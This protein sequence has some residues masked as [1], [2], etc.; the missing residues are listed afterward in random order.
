VAAVPIAS[1]KP[2]LK[3]KKSLKI[4][5]WAKINLSLI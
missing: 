2:E 5:E 3:K 4:F 1:Q